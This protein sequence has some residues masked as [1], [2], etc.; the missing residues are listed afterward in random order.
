[1]AFNVFN[2]CARFGFNV[3]ISIALFNIGM[4]ATGLRINRIVI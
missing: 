2:I 4:L 1:M 3:N